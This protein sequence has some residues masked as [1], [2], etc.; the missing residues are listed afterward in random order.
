MAR[1]KNRK[2]AKKKAEEKSGKK[3]G[4]K[5]AEPA[6]KKAKV[7]AAAAP[8]I[9]LE[10][11]DI[12]HGFGDNLVL[13]NVNFRVERGAIVSLVGPSGCGKSTLLR[14]IVG[15]HP[16]R[17]GTVRTYSSDGRPP[18]VADL[19]PLGYLPR[20][21]LAPREIRAG[22]NRQCPNGRMGTR[23]LKRYFTW[24]GLTGRRALME[25]S[26]AKSRIHFRVWRRGRS[27]Y[28]RTRAPRAARARGWRYDS[29][30]Y[31]VR[32]PEQ[33]AAGTRLDGRGE[34]DSSV[35]QQGNWPAG[36]SFSKGTTFRRWG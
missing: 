19:E 15:T 18:V 17:R 32:V 1:K 12:H 27:T 22:L 9:V 25:C 30:V 4:K 26:V 2:K 33:R 35:F 11:E 28:F 8:D 5:T 7:E 6:D 16:P 13:H 29:I 23:R 10:C 14:A 20:V 31:K 24:L 3:S 34:R 21:R 36:E